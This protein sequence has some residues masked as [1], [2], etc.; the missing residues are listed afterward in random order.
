M[1][2]IKV[3]DGQHMIE[4]KYDKVFKQTATQNEIY[5]FVRGNKIEMITYLLYR[6]HLRRSQGVQFYHLCLWIDRFGKDLHD[7]WSSLGR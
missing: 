4:S 5:G 3:A 6:E 2:S 1:K 7:V